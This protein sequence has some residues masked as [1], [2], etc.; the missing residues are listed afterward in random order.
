MTNT[1]TIYS[2]DELEKY[3]KNYTFKSRKERMG[4]KSNY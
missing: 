2:T 3:K 1:A 4:Y